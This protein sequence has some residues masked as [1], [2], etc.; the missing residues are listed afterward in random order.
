MTGKQIK[1][2]RAIH[3]LKGYELA[4]MLNITPDRLSKMENGH[5]PVTEE[6]A[7]KIGGMFEVS[8][9]DVNNIVFGNV[10]CS[11]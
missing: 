10:N 4:K 8:Q 6:I 11:N 9:K 1:I 3:N 2:I 7:G 5:Y